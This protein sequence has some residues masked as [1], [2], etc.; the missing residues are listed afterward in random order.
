MKTSSNMLIVIER[1]LLLNFYGHV[2][3]VS[4]ICCG[5]CACV[6]FRSRLSWFCMQ[7]DR[8]CRISSSKMA[9]ELN[10]NTIP[11]MPPHR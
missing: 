4:L 3:Q 1:E 8:L 9:G 7:Y 2:H 11:V 5:I 10:A 6:H